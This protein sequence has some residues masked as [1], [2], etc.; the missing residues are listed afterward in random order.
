[1]NLTSL[2]DNIVPLD[3]RS[4]LI[5][6]RGQLI[7]EHYRNDLTM[8]K[9]AKINSCTKSVL[10][11]LL[12]IAVDQGTLPAL[13]TPISMFFPELNA[14][15]DPRKKEITLYHLLTMTPGFRWTEFG[16]LNSF[17]K[18]TRTPNWVNY[19]L[20]QPLSDPPGTRMVYNSGASQLLSAILVQSSGMPVAEFAEAHL[21][22][23]LGIETYDWEQDPQGI[24]TGGFGLSLRPTDMLKFGQLYLQ[25]GKWENKQLISKEM[26]SSTIKPAI[27][28]DAPNRGYYALH[29]WMDAY[30]LDDKDDSAPTLA[31]YYA[32]GFGGQYIH[33]VPS[34]EI[35]TVLTN[36]KRQKEQPPR[37]VFRQFIAPL[38][39]QQN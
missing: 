31:Y 2:S 32:R 8:R 21:F 3:L 29:W 36:D 26:V 1:M 24:H 4:C 11:A 37:D 9:I 15:P 28:I 7:F 38:L 27:T 10:S 20:A 13:T 22:K 5:S 14:D 16:G 19:V 34:L 25:H 12:S 30:S 39:M 17:P 33:I 6:Q 18:M 23:P 35:V